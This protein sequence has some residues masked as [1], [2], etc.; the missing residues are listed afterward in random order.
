[1]ERR[2]FEP[3]SLKLVGA[4]VVFSLV[5]QPTTD[6]LVSSLIDDPE[7]IARALS[8]RWWVFLAAAALFLFIIVRQFVAEREQN[9]FRLKRLEAVVEAAGDAIYSSSPDGTITSWNRA[10]EVMYGYSREEAV[11]SGAQMLASSER[12][13]EEQ[14]LLDSAARD[15]S[16]QGLETERMTKDG[17]QINVGI[18][19]S[20]IHDRD[21]NDIG[22]TIVSRDISEQ[23][24]VEDDLFESVERLQ[25][26]KRHREL[27]L[28]Q[29]VMA[30]EKE[31]KRIASGI[32][33]DPIQVMSSVA[34]TLD[35]MAHNAAYDE[36]LLD[37]SRTHVRGAIRRLRTLVFELSPPDL[38]ET[39]LAPAIETFLRENSKDSGLPYEMD[40]WISVPISTEMS[41]LLYR[42]TQEAV[43]NVTKHADASL[44][45]VVVES[46]DEG[47]SVRV[48]DDGKG[49]VTDAA[50]SATHF[51]LKEM[52][53]R[54]EL[55][56]G[57]LRYSSAPGAGTTVEF[58]APPSRPLWVL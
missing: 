34:M 41:Y 40:D 18:S 14:W 27:L 22:S 37:Q 13:R 49:F 9:F 48:V 57:W 7:D 3:R 28:R 42:V 16:V 23:R 58:W 10:A 6:W 46:N 56:G 53:D 20:P 50:L 32:H 2:L 36:G 35:L 26:S 33:D 54:L 52:R 30:E 4:F 11:G 43:R 19:M 55:A 51:G 5:W 29:L 39:G 47:V 45:R 8:L 31:R 17:R 38:A 15:Q 1:M 12:H 21:G 25:I 24:K 44:V